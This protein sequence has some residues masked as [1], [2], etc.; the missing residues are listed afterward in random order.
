M[1]LSGGM[2]TAVCSCYCES[3]NTERMLVSLRDEIL[4]FL[5]RRRASKIHQKISL[6]RRVRCNFHR[7]VTVLA[8]HDSVAGE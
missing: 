5:W 1:V 7:T 6:I 4:F 3:Q 8:L 2:L